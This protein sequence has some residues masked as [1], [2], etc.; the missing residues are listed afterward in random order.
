MRVATTKRQI[1]AGRV[2]LGCSTG[3]TEASGR[4]GRADRAPPRPGR[5]PAT[6]PR[7]ALSTTEA[8]SRSGSARSGLA[9]VGAGVSWPS[10]AAIPAGRSG[11]ARARPPGVMEQE[12]TFWAY[13]DRAGPRGTLERSWRFRGSDRRAVCSTTLSGHPWDSGRVGMYRLTICC[14][15]RR[16]PL[17]GAACDEDR[18]GAEREA[19]GRVDQRV[20]LAEAR[21]ESGGE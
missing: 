10:A 21:V 6:R 5:H 20:E 3:G 9:T 14:T 16:V 4:A 2:R 11:G 19:Q 1:G 18:R 7:R 12:R 13:P 15:P 17:R 8:R